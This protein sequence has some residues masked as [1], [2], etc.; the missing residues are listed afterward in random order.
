M[1]KLKKIHKFEYLDWSITLQVCSDEADFIIN[2]ERIRECEL[3][4]DY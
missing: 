2:Y 4:S 3:S 1:K